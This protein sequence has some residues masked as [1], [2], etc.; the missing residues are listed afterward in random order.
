M[1]NRNLKS[2]Y[3]MVGVMIAL[4][5]AAFLFTIGGVELE[6]ATE[7]GYSIGDALAIRLRTV[8]HPVA[9]VTTF[10]IALAVIIGA[11]TLFIKRRREPWRRFLWALCGA[12]QATSVASFYY[13]IGDSWMVP[14]SPGVKYPEVVVAFSYGYDLRMV[15]YALA[16][17]IV[18]TA[19]SILLFLNRT[20][21]GAP[22]QPTAP[23]ETM[24]A[25]AR[26]RAAI[27]ILRRPRDAGDQQYASDPAAS[28]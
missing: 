16:A 3:Y 19:F 22:A 13:M 10:S 15:S 2:L 14:P 27:R 6:G 11:T 20:S 1:S 8:G 7:P 24:G 12:F 23:A 9:A 25:A 5:V 26:V 18:A 21:S 17:T 4:A 28:V